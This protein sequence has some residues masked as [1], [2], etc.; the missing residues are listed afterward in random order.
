[1]YPVSSNT[2]QINETDVPVFVR[3]IP[4][5]EDKLLAV[6]V[7]TTGLPKTKNAKTQALTEFSFI[8]SDPNFVAFTSPEIGG[9]KFEIT[10]NE[11][12]KAFVKALKFATKV[13]EDQI[14]RV[15]D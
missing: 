14:N 3:R 9:I 6:Q 13:L 7:G 5:V 1:M 15:D 4:T 2:T 11:Q 10:G 12:L 8:T